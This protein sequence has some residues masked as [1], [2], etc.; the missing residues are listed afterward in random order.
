[1][2]AQGEEDLERWLG[3]LKSVLARREERVKERERERQQAQAEGTGKG[4]VE[5]TEAM[6]L[7]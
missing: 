3:A 6:S 2:G 1:M 5:R 7:R 4:L